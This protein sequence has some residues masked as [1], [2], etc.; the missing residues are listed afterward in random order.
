MRPGKAIRRLFG[1]TDEQTGA[2]AGLWQDG[3]FA[4]EASG[5]ASMFVEAYASVRSCMQG[6]GALCHRAYARHGVQ[7]IV[8]RREGVVTARCL[9]VGGKFPKAYGYDSF[10]LEVLLTR[11]VGLEKSGKWFSNSFK[12]EDIRVVVAPGQWVREEVK[13]PRSF[14][15]APSLHF[16]NIVR[17]FPSLYVDVQPSDNPA[18]V[19]ARQYINNNRHIRRYIPPQTVA[20]YLDGH[21]HGQVY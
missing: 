15:G 14:E 4:V 11:L 16:A 18:Y 13:F 17:R 6:Q 19:W 7:I 10:A 3:G 8:A 5:D 2:L 21:G 9:T 20:P 1:T 12:P